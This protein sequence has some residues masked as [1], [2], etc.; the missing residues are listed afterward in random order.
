MEI[1]SDE[2]SEQI[3]E[4]FARFG[5]VV[6]V[7]NVVETGLVHALLQ[8]DF[9]ASVR[10]EYIKAKGQ[11]FDRKKY[12]ADFDAFMQ[13]H[14]ADTMGTLVKKVQALTTLDNKL[15]ER[16]I[17][18][19]KRRDFLVHHYWREKA[20]EFS[21]PAG[22][23]AMIEELKQDAETFEQLDVDI[24]SAMKPIRE[25]LGIKDGIL[26]ARVEEEMARLKADQS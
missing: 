24:R 23:A 10:E 9:L 26:D 17:A 14:F 20:V 7:A 12:E 3:K 11:G 15:R 25:K 13:R 16:I 19:K 8:L 5:L 2:E 1:E 6:Y 18:A 22:R 21:A 4:T